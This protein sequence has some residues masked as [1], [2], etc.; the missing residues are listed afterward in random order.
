MKKRLIV[1]IVLLILFIPLVSAGFW[2]WITG[3]ATTA[4]ECTDSDGG[5]NYSIRG[6]VFDGS[7]NLVDICSDPGAYGTHVHEGYCE[8]NQYKSEEHYCP[9]G[10]RNGA[11]LSSEQEAINLSKGECTD[12]DGGYNI[13]VKGEIRDKV[14]IDGLYKDYCNGN[15]LTEYVC[16]YFSTGYR[17]DFN[18]NYP[19]GFYGVP[20]EVNCPNYCK[21][22]AC[23]E[24]PAEA[25]PTPVKESST[26]DLV[27]ENIL[28]KKSTIDE[29]NHPIYRF[30]VYVKNIGGANAQTSQLKIQISPSQPQSLIMA[31]GS[32]SY[33]CRDSFRFVSG[34]VLKPGGG[35]I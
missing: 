6:Y 24:S 1:G 17:S 30:E 34:N 20:K 14:Y 4:D 22:G 32:I 21:D 8:N 13:Y 23:L 5:K 28:L 31:N 35:E 3:R 7:I 2:D 12:T 25:V 15:R 11:C 33:I 27:I 9:Y 29:D 26:P 19:P 18:R 10:C 16:E